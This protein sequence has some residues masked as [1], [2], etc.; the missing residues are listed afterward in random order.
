MCEERHALGGLAHPGTTA[1]R[2]APVLLGS[3]LVIVVEPEIDAQDGADAR[4][5]T[6]EC[7]LHRTGE[8]AAVSKTGERLAVLGSALHECAG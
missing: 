5:G 2:R 1:C 8:P 6:G 3:G 4:I 7:P